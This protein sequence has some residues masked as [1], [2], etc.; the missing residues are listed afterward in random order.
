MDGGLTWRRLSAAVAVACCCCCFPPVPGCLLFPIPVQRLNRI[1]QSGVGSAWASKRPRGRVLISAGGGGEGETHRV[2]FALGR[3]VV[4]PGGWFDFHGERT[5]KGER[6]V[7]SRSC[8]RTPSCD[9]FRLRQFFC[10]A[11]EAAEARAT[12]GVC[13]LLAVASI[14]S[15][16]VQAC[17]SCSSGCF[18]LHFCWVRACS[19]RSYGRDGDDVVP[20]PYPHPPAPTPTP[21][22][23]LPPLPPF[24]LS[25]IH[26]AYRTL[27]NPPEDFP[28]AIT[29]TSPLH[30][31]VRSSVLVSVARARLNFGTKNM[32]G[33][34]CT[35]GAF[36]PCDAL[37]C[38]VVWN[39]TAELAECGSAS[40]A[41]PGAYPVRSG[42]VQSGASGAGPVF[43][44]LLCYFLVVCGLPSRVDFVSFQTR[45]FLF[46]VVFILCA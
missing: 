39:G 16:G 9:A 35:A 14:G 18:R 42:C 8:A 29:S 21:T 44:F 5:E 7:D 6:G 15:V 33:P 20:S 30:W 19:R 11:A 2:F 28:A 17:R 22:P 45:E 4:G 36:S 31:F 32:A 24:A 1:A 37:C 10:F 40:G 34:A 3:V 43:G 26:G 13:R 38:G 25:F 23:T 46:C 41:W 12:V 27:P